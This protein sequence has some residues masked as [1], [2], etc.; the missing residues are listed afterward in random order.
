MGLWVWVGG[1]REEDWV[2]VIS[3]VTTELMSL[4]LGFPEYW[5]ASRVKLRDRLAILAANRGQVPLRLGLLEAVYELK[6]CD[7]LCALERA[8]NS[9]VTS[10]GSAEQNLIGPNQRAIPT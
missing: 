9:M 3:A 1:E 5:V 10:S 6:Q 8:L 2:V 4:R 7:I